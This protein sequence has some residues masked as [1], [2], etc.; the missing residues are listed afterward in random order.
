MGVRTL[1]W[2]ESCYKDITTEIRQTITTLHQKAA[3]VDIAWT[4]GHAS[5]VGNEIA[6]ALAKEAATEAMNQ[7]ECRR[8]TTI[9]EVKEAIKK[10]QISR[11]K[12]KWDNLEH[13]RAY[14]LLVPKVDSKKFLDI[15]NRKGFCHI[16]QLQTGYSRLNDYMNKLSQCDNK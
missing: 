9:L 5:I 13:D 8:S 7:P 11:W 4:P 2:K 1:N 3:D 16:L 10:T 6:D 15:P 14:H 12:I